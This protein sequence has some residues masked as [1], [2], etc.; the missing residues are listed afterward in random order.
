MYA[1]LAAFVRTQAPVTACDTKP[2][3]LP[4]DVQAA[5]TAIGCRDIS[6]EQLAT[7]LPDLAPTCL[8]TTD[9]SNT[10]PT[11]A[12]LKR[13]L[14]FGSARGV[15]SRLLLLLELAFVGFG[16]V[17]GLFARDPGD[18]FCEQGRPAALSVGASFGYIEKFLRF[19]CLGCGSAA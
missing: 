18:P 2:L 10:N 15:R 6:R 19:Q 14:G 5:L 1:V 3:A 16:P 8:P 13:H 11:G 9:L 4:V 12:D 7:H 17:V